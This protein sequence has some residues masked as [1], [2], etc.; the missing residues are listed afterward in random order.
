[1]LNIDNLKTKILKLKESSNVI[2]F[3]AV[4]TAKINFINA[5]LDNSNFPKIPEDYKNFLQ[6]TNGIIFNLYKLYGTNNI[7]RENY[8][9]PNIYDINKTF[10]HKNIVL[11]NDLIIGSVTNHLITYNSLDQDYKIKDNIIFETIF[12]FTTFDNLFNHIEQASDY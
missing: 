3:P 10:A 11:P 6:T 1:M 12:K 7:K 8:I 5:M 2:L 9:Y 4:N